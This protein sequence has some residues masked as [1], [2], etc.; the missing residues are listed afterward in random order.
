VIVVDASAVANA[1][2]DDGPVGQICRAE[3]ARDVHWAAPEHL[4][5]ETFSAIRGRH[6]GGKIGESRCT[7]ALQALGSATIE[8]MRTIVLLP[9]MWE[10]RANVSGYDAAYVAAAETL[11][12]P[13][14]TSDVRLARVTG[15]RCAVRLAI[16]SG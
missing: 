7:D 4:I 8:L 14:I 2:T 6:L 9:R 11:D 3:L 12:C 15:L 13:L 1:L 10:L 16:P 5:V